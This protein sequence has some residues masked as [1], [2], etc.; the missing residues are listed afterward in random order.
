MGTYQL[1]GLF[2]YADDFLPLFPAQFPYAVVGL[3]HLGRLN[4]DRAPGGALVVHDACHLAFHGGCH[5]YHEPAVSHGG[6]GVL[7]HQALSLRLPQY[8]VQRA[9]DVSFR[10]GQ[11]SPEAGQ[12]GGG[13][14]AHL[15]PFVEHLVYLAGDIGEGTYSLCH[16]SQGGIGEVAVATVLAQQG[17]KP[18]DGAQRAAQVE[19]L[20]FLHVGVLHPYSQNGFP[21]IQEVVHGHFPLRAAEFAKLAHLRQPLSHVFA[22]GAEG[23]LL[24]LLLAQRAEASLLEHLA[25]LA[26][27][28]L[29]FQVV[30]VNHGANLH[31]FPDTAKG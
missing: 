17:D 5:G 10:A 13:V 26:E 16:L 15:S 19:Q 24:H 12:L 2:Q 30:R 9:G 21:G 11:L 4:V 18:L 31:I 1:G 6:G 3:H 20:L 25:Y 29:G 22:P 8:A 23:H 27:A 14:V 7:V 28:Y